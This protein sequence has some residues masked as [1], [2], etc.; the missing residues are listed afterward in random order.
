M[1]CAPFGVC[2]FD[3]R[4]RLF[5]FAATAAAA[6]ALRLW[7]TAVFALSPAAFPRAATT[8]VNG[9]AGNRRPVA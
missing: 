5:L 9:A 2:V 1:A 6:A 3:E 7:V 8:R 4:R